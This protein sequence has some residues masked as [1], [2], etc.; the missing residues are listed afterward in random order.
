M[1]SGQV[2]GRNDQGGEEK[3]LDR[4]SLPLQTAALVNKGCP[5]FG[6]AEMKATDLGKR[7]VSIIVQQG[8]VESKQGAGLLQGSGFSVE[9]ANPAMELKE[10]AMRLP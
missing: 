2:M 10:K 6:F 5:K 4:A 1:S 3:T 8:D 9:I 7:R